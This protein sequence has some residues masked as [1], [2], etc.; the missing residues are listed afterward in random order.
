MPLLSVQNLL[1]TNGVVRNGKLTTA[2]SVT[3]GGNPFS[4]TKYIWFLHEWGGECWETCFSV[5][6]YE[7]GG[8]ECR[9]RP[10]QHLFFFDEPT[11]PFLPEWCGG[12]WSTYYCDNSEGR[13]YSGR[14]HQHLFFYEYLVSTRMGWWMLGLLLL[15]KQIRRWW[16][17]VSTPLSPT[18]FLLRWEISIYTRMG[19]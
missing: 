8:Y 15:R 6:R 7:G 19:W 2:A 4:F 10:H 18:P 9:P 16:I 12:L 14:P 5:N 13:G 17:R 11:Y 3:V 1:S